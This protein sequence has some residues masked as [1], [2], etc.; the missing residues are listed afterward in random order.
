MAGTG[1]RLTPETDEVGPWGPAAP[2]CAPSHLPGRGAF[3][4]ARAALLAAQEL[5]ELLFEGRVRIS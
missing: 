5:A 3:R 1:V 2:G 4:L